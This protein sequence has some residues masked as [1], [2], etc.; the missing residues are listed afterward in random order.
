MSTLDE[1][2][3][4]STPVGKPAATL[5]DAFSEYDREQKHKAGVELIRQ[6]AQEIQPPQAAKVIQLNR[7]TG[8]PTDVIGRNLSDV[9]RQAQQD[10]RQQTLEKYPA[11]QWLYANDPDSAAILQNDIGI[12]GP[13]TQAPPF[14]KKPTAA[15]FPM[16]QMGGFKPASQAL[17][18]AQDQRAAEL[19]DY[20]NTLLSRPIPGE[21]DASLNG[22]VE[23]ALRS[24]ASAAPDT[25]AALWGLAEAGART[26]SEYVTGPMTG[27]ILP[28]DIFLR[29]AEK[30][31]ANRQYQAGI[32]EDIRGDQRNLGF[33]E[34]SVMSGFKSLGQN[35]LFL[36][37]TMATGTP[38]P[39]LMGMSASTGGEAFGKAQDKGVPL[40]QALTFA[41]SQAVIEYATE[42][43]PLGKLIKDVQVGEGFL[44]TLGKNIAL[45]IPGEQA[46]T[47]LQDMNEWAI[48]NPEK[49]FTQYIAERPE[50]A[51]QTLIATIVASGGQVA[52][53]HGFQK[54]AEAMSE[55]ARAQAEQARKAQA[56]QEYHQNLQAV[57][58]Q[59]NQTEAA[60]L[61]VEGQNAIAKALQAADADAMV[62]IDAKTFG[63][64]LEQS[65][66]PLQTAME[67]MPAVAEQ[68]V[69]AAARGGDLIIPTGEFM[70]HLSNTPAI[71]PLLE[72]VRQDPEAM[73]MA[74]AN[75]MAQ[76]QTERFLAEAE[77]VATA[78]AE[79][80]AWQTSKKAV[81]TELQRQ[82]DEAGGYS[83]DANQK[84]VRM[85]SA[86]Y[87]TLA[88]KDQQQFPNPEAAMK[89]FPLV[90]QNGRFQAPGEGAFEQADIQ[91]EQIKSA[92]GNRGTYDPN[93]LNQSDSRETID[94]EIV[95]EAINSKTGK[96]VQIKE[97]ASVAMKEVDERINRLEELIKCLE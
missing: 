57:V 28:E 9:E 11:M 93:I 85:V 66:I 63:Q 94:P 24:L 77:K 35:M 53:A 42:M 17:R 82:M 5:D 50:A 16:D 80:V 21:Y 22:P 88:A 97:L 52:V 33:V 67:T 45:E 90:F 14:L 31:Q 70:A 65:G 49:P 39:M 30:M 87:E 6:R 13:I 40:E 81:E 71:G 48:L 27:K 12:L 76:E 69:M 62:T 72:N 15:D 23:N 96:T 51:A 55:P 75:T 56:A 84:H 95:V 60:S 26:L 3:G 86:F 89:A 19:T 34:Q 32:G 92:I 54:F 41:A 59:I 46:A 74:E 91:Q 47:I 44:K 18:Q 37:M 4:D 43:I 73:T 1:A 20:T 79:D 61:G 10:V 64:V 36:P 83:K 38:G 78:K 58:E 7:T 2:F 8:L 29:I 68:Y 25:N